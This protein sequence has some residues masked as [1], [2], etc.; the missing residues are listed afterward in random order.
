MA[1]A[2]QPRASVTA[3]ATAM[4]RATHTR[5]DRP[6]LIDDPWG[7][8]LVLDAEMEAI[9]MATTAGLDEAE[10]ERIAA[11]GSARER[12]DEALR[13]HPTY[14]TVVLRTR[15]TEDAL[16]R[17]VARGIGQYVLVGAGMDSF[18]LRRPPFATD[19]EVYELDLPASQEFKCARLAEHRAEPQGRVHFVAA[20]LGETA[21]DAALEGSGFDQEAPAFFSW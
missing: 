11:L 19:L 10:A 1:Q 6:A 21:V 5:L 9:G 8:R 13:A 3:L 2:D 14:A 16:E 15:Y 7:D 20:D 4:M 18:A 12:T 17:A